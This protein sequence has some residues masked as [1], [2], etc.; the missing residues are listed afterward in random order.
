MREGPHENR[1]ETAGSQGIRPF[2]RCFGESECRQRSQNV[3]TTAAL[4]MGKDRKSV[5]YSGL[6]RRKPDAILV[7]VES[8]NIIQERGIKMKKF[9]KALYHELEECAEMIDIIVEK[10]NL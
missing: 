9:F 8:F 6:K 3:Q 7:Y 10:G 2:F 5:S 1:A 4:Q